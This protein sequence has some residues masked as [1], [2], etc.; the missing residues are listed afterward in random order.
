MPN[1]FCPPL[2]LHIE[3]LTG[4]DPAK[5][6]SPQ[7]FLQ[8]ILK[9][10]DD[11]AALQIGNNNGHQVDF[12]VKYRE[13]PLPST[14]LDTMPDCVTGTRNPY[15]EFAPP[16]WI[17]KSRSF[18]VPMSTLRQY[19]ADVSERIPVA[20]ARFSSYNQNTTVMRE[21]YDLL[22]S[23]AGALISSIDAALV[24]Q[25]STQ[26]GKNVV[27]G[28][29]AAVPLTYD[30]TAQGVNEALFRI[31]NDM[32]ENEFCDFSNV[33]F[34]GTGPFINQELFRTWWGNC[35][36]AQGINLAA[37]AAS[38]QNMFFD[39][40]SRATWG[41]GHVGVF[42]KG[43]VS[44]LR[45]PQYGGNFTGR[46]GTSEYF[47]MSLPVD[48]FCC[49]Q[50]YLDRLDIDVQIKEYDCNP[51]LALDGAPAAQQGPGVMVMLSWSGTLFVRPDMYRAGDPLDGTN[52]TLRY[53]IDAP[54]PAP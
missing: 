5:R 45:N 20:G 41:D 9:N 31:I 17:T 29:A 10:Q 53:D 26:F 2:L 37:Q 24:V 49:P 1:G 54:V 50:D 16:G 23:E 46:L 22:I 4:C 12:T 21:V 25:M 39:K 8:M 7:G 52:G 42:E 43:S 6:L 11:N 13:R 19:C 35:C 18:W 3:A 48:E 51:N 15:K 28:S 40:N 33:A 27:T 38:F 34:V 14:T 32:R 30:L 36:S 47:T 44:L